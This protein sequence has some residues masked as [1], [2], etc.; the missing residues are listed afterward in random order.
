MMLFSVTDR[1]QGCGLC[2]RACPAS[3]VRSP[4]AGEPPVALAGRESHC[5][6]C[7]HCVI[8]CPTGAFTHALLPAE[9][10]EPVRR[11]ARA[12]FAS[13]RHLLM[14]R[15]ACR[16]YDPSPVSHQELLTLIEAV[17]HAP[18]G[19][20]ARQAGYVIVDGPER[21]DVVRRAVLDWIE[22]EVATGSARA[23]ELHLAGAARAAARDKDVIFRGAPHVAVVHAPTQGVTPALDAAIAGAW[24]DIAASAAGLG[25]CWCGYLIFALAGHPP[26]GELLGIPAGHRGYAALLLGRPVMR[27]TS[28]PPRDMPEVRFF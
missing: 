7:G 27:P 17:R 22:G 13:M 8:A 11:K 20:N 1:C 19:H 12:D 9:A 16:M 5:I 18:T 21:M 23:A 15:R 2:A 6:R 25:A 28:I 14:S 24:L 26:V 4:K 10:F 3:L